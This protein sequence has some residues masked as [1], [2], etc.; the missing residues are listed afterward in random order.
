MWNN[1]KAEYVGK[2]PQVKTTS[3]MYMLVFERSQVNMTTSCSKDHS[4][5]LK[6][7]MSV[8][9]QSN[10]TPNA[11][12]VKQNYIDIFKSCSIAVN[13][14]SSNQELSIYSRIKLQDVPCFPSRN[15]GKIC[16]RNEVSPIHKMRREKIR[17]KRSK[18][19][20]ARF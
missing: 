9:F 15:I 14:S 5:S 16:M 18:S 19:F 10:I 11:K 12:Q 6:N 1:G 20:F 4:A 3:Y 17:Y 2:H 8:T 7:I 13:A